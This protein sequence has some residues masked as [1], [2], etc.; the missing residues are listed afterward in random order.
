MGVI[1]TGYDEVI[2]LSDGKTIVAVISP[3]IGMSQAYKRDG[4]GSAQYTPSWGAGDNLL[5]LRATA[6]GADIIADL[7]NVNWSKDLPVSEGGVSLGTGL[8]LAVGNLT[9]SAATYYFEASWLDNDVGFSSPVT[10]SIT[11]TRN[12]IGTNATWLNVR[13]VDRIDQGVAVTK[14][15]GHMIAE[16]FRGSAIDNDG[17]EYK[18][19][20][21]PFQASDQLDA[22]HPLVIDGSIRFRTKAQSEAAPSPS[23][24]TDALIATLDPTT[25]QPANGAWSDFKEILIRETAVQKFAH[26]LVQVRDT[27]VDSTI[28]SKEFVVSDITD[29][30]SCK[31]IPSARSI[32]NGQGTITVKPEVSNGTRQLTAEELGGCTYIRDGNFTLFESPQLN[33]GTPAITAVDGIYKASGSGVWSVY[34]PGMSCNGKRVVVRVKASV[35]TDISINN[36]GGWGGDYPFALVAGQEREFSEIVSGGLG[37]LYFRFNFTGDI[38]ISFLQVGEGY[39]F[40]WVAQHSGQ[41][42]GFVDRDVTPTA[43]PINHTV[44]DGLFLDTAPLV[45][46]SKGQLLKLITAERAV[47]WFEID[48]HVGTA[49]NIK[50][51]APINT[52]VETS[53]VAGSFEGASIYICNARY[54]TPGI[55]PIVVTGHDMDGRVGW[56]VSA[57]RP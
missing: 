43:H 24:V 8:T 14:N 19:F 12:E 10:A 4:S 3:A 1:A 30:W 21:S 42:Y 56:A 41:P 22:N 44:T 2:D 5:T 13:G 34:L 51:A 52:W 25:N 26:F 37:D 35:T 36:S 57:V 6:N 53:L 54:T 27:A 38:E 28:Y 23:V 40:D 46:A 11:L 18:W 17:L 7:T 45:N 49:I 39:W 50:T 16:L 31:G 9:A 32:K 29:P 15:W 33:S 55:T 48:A 47:H 20:L